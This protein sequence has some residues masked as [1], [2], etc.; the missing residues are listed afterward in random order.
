[1]DNKNNIMN[2]DVYNST[3]D[4]SSIEEA[5]DTSADLVLTG[6]KVDAPSGIYLRGVGAWLLMDTELFDVIA[7]NDGTLLA[8]ADGTEVFSF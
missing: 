2:I 5:L 8:N 4:A 6:I 7:Y 1:M 3:H